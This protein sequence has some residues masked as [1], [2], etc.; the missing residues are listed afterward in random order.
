MRRQ[1]KTATVGYLNKGM[2]ETKSNLGAPSIAS[3]ETERKDGVENL[4]EKM[5]V[6]VKVFCNITT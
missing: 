1:Q 4:L 2:L 3:L 5:L 6:V